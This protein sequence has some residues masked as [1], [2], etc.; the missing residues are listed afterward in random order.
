MVA[1]FERRYVERALAAHAGNISRAARA[2]GKN[3]RAFFELMR[4]R[5][6]DAERFRQV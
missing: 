3:R 5:G 4:R 1:E 6:V 2:V